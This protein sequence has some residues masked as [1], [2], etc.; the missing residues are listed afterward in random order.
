MI[1]IEFT[2]MESEENSGISYFVSATATK[3]L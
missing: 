1:N 2:Y 3:S